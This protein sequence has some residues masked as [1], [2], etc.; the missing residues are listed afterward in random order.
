M[1]K[2]M[3]KVGCVVLA[4]GILSVPAWSSDNSLA[5]SSDLPILAKGCH[6]YG[7]GNGGRGKGD[8]TGSGGGS[9]GNGGVCPYG[10]K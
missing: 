4:L 2:K 6:Q 3:I 10:V 7:A 5:D 1:L 8:G 9:R